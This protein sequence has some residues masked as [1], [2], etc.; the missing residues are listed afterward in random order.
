MPISPESNTRRI[1]TR[2]SKTRW[3][4]EFHPDMTE[5]DKVCSL[6]EWGMS[7][8]SCRQ[9]DN[10]NLLQPGADYYEFD[11]VIEAGK[12]YMVGSDVATA[13]YLK[14]HRSYMDP[15][16]WMAAAV[17]YAFANPDKKLIIEGHGSR[18][19]HYQV[20]K[21]G[22]FVEVALPHHGQGGERHWAVSEDKPRRRILI[23]V[24]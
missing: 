19:L 21:R 15:N 18:P 6:V 23:N 10:N 16:G 17:A 8:A 3:Q 22:N 20:Y 13:D 12:S 2:I 5:Y 7:H 4:H 14:S 24:D 11:T 9:T 1:S